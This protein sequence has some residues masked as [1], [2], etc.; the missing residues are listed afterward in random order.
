MKQIKFTKEQLERLLLLLGTA[1]FYD[2]KLPYKFSTSGFSAQELLND[3]DLST[4]KTIINTINSAIQS[5]L[6]DEGLL[7]GQEETVGNS[8]KLTMLNEQKELI[9]LAYTYRLYKQ[10][11][12][13]QN[14]AL[15]AQLK[16]LKERKARESWENMTPEQMDA[17]IQEITDLLDEN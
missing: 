4:Y 3:L 1:A 7:I 17:K 12:A 13:T 11:K 15:R 6:T 9:Q 8:K 14:K 5:E 10:Q 16:E 2:W